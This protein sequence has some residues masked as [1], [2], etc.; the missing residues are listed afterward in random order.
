MLAR[1]LFGHKRYAENAA[2]AEDTVYWHP[3]FGL[4]F[5]VCAECD[6]VRWARPSSARD[7]PRSQH[8]RKARACKAQTIFERS[9]IHEDGETTWGE[10]SFIATGAT[11]RAGNFRLE[12]AVDTHALLLIWINFNADSDK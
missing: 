6:T 9:F 7:Q 12:K 2:F 4:M 3:R 11:A 5:R 10:V 1:L 8:D